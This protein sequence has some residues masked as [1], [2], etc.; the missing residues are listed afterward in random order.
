V[1]YNHR[2]AGI[3]FGCLTISATVVVYFD[4]FL[5]QFGKRVCAH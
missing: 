5:A 4:Q 1:V 3:G 2:L